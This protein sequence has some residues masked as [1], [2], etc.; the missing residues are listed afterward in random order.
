MVLGLNIKTNLGGTNIFCFET[1]LIEIRSV[2][3]LTSKEPNPWA[4]I[5][6]PS[7]S[8]CDTS[9]R[10][11]EISSDVSFTVYPKRRDSSVVNSL[12]FNYLNTF[13]KYGAILAIFLKISKQ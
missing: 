7:N 11:E 6:F 1:G 4:D 12:L 2:F 5:T 13:I 8:C 9:E 3:F 10:N